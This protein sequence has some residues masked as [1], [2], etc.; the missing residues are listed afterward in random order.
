MSSRL[1]SILSL[2]LLSALGIAACRGEE[3]VTDGASG[4]RS[5]SNTGGRSSGGS[6]SS[7]GSGE[8]GEGGD[9]GSK[10]VTISFRAQMGEEE[11]A[12][13]KKYKKQGATE[14]EVTPQDLRLYVSELRVVTA[15][16]LEVPV[17]IEDRS[18]WQAPSVALL[19]FEDASGACKNGNAPTNHRITGTVP[20]GDYTGV[21][22]STAVPLDLNHAD[23]ATLP[24]PLEAGGMTW[25]WLFGYKFIRAELV[26]TATPEEGM[27]PGLGIFHLGSTGCD[28]RPPAEGGAG[29]EGGAL[30][31]NY[32]APPALDCAFQ[33]RNEIRLENFDSESDVIVLDV[34]E[35]MAE[36]DLSVD[37]QCHSMQM[38]AACEPLFEMAGVDLSTGA[39]TDA[40]SIF[41]VSN[42]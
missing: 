15:E 5:P 16:G 42:P 12:C 25:G 34:S 2:S 18:P 32:G 13:G 22:F 6:S 23:P 7:G 37:S 29:G 17:E 36:V 9:A 20:R 28:N 1:P 26:A 33:N 8:G 27:D 31:P 24:A 41:R 21:V 39:A 35:M 14:V 4:G 11:F 19:D 40:Q 30:E 10:R 3:S 38:Q